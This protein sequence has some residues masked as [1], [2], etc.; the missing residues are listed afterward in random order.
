MAVELAGAEAA[1][2]GLSEAESFLEALAV[3]GQTFVGLE[4]GRVEIEHGLDERS[5]FIGEGV[6]DHFVVPAGFDQTGL[7][8]DLEVRTQRA[9]AHFE[10]VHHLADAEVGEKQAC[11]DA[12]PGGVCEGFAEEDNIVHPSYHDIT[13]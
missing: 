11:E 12:D 1:E 7:A 3:S 8:D 4:S 13:I 9:L 10:G 6:A 5:G 2:S